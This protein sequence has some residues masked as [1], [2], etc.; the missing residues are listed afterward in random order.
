LPLLQ[1]PS[2][3]DVTWRNLPVHGKD[4]PKAT[5]SADKLKRIFLEDPELKADRRRC[6]DRM[7]EVASP[8]LRADHHHKLAKKMG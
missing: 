3:K 8:I 5:V 2:K 6:D 7:A 4:Y 1:A